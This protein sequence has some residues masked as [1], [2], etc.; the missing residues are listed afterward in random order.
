[1]TSK[2]VQLSDNQ[3]IRFSGPDVRKFLQG[4]LSCNMERL[5]PTQSLRGAICNLQGRVVADLR[6]LQVH[7]YCLMQ[8]GAGMA[9][10]VVTTLS[11]YA[12]FSKVKLDIQDS[13]P[14]P[15]GILGTP[16]DLVTALIGSIPQE[17][18]SVVQTEEASL[19]RL[20]GNAPRFELWFHNKQAADTFR[21]RVPAAQLA[22][23]AAWRRADI[24]AGIVHVDSSTTEEY[25]PQLLNYDIS[26]VIDFKKGC[27]TGQ[28]VVA[29]MFYRGI[30]K[31]RLFLASTGAEISRDDHVHQVGDGEDRLSPI[32]A[33][34][35]AGPDSG[36]PNLL[37][38]VL[39]TTAVEEGRQ[40][41]LA[42]QPEAKL[43]VTMLEY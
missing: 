33:F 35:N 19:I 5:A 6:V 26:G 8:V 17:P 13:H 21:A 20:P 42:D 9:N 12:V 14:A 7:D 2:I 10:I 37:L 32:L 29:R 27:Y 1:M 15:F 18:D 39:G 16:D 24:A 11:K 28:E 34:S 30:A 38:T 23:L 36:E 25:T 41:T 31:K 43:T 40:F 22:N 4:Q 3:F